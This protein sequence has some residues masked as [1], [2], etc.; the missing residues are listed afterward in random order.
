LPTARV[1]A[2]PS[3][4][5]KTR[6][7]LHQEQI[8]RQNERKHRAVH[9]QAHARATTLVAKERAN[10]K[11]NCHTTAEVIVQVEGEFR[12]RAFL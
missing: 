6:K 1:I 9:T 5:R 2:L 11:E 3:L 4:P 8:A 10:E 12:A 7:T